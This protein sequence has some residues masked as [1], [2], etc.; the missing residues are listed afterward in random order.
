M[1]V[2]NRHCSFYYENQPVT[3]EINFDPEKTALLIIDMQNYF[4]QRPEYDLNDEND[5][6]E[7]KR[8][9]QFYDVI[10]EAVIPNNEKILKTFRDKE[11]LVAFARIATQ[12]SSGE[13]RSL[14]Q[15]ESG[16]NNLYLPADEEPSQIIDCLKPIKDELVFEKTTDSAVTG[17]NLRLILSN[18]G[19]TDVIVTGVFTDQCVSGTVRSLADESFKVW[20]IEDACRASTEEIQN[21]E[22]KILNNIYCNVI[23]TKELI[24]YLKNK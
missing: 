20:L 3:G 14:S 16:F 24:N 11:M 4:V 7:E 10:E 6:R 2:N 23:N 18:I 17:T 5:I 12:L 21:S 19:I 1:K 13:D 15:K 8:W 9:K 22:L